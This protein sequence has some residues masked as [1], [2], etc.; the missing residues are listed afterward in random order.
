MRSST[1]TG[2]RTFLKTAVAVSVAGSLLAGCA[3]SGTS[4]SGDGSSTADSGGTPTTSNNAGGGAANDG[5]SAFGGWLD[6][7]ANYDSVTDKTGASTVAVKVGAE[8]N[9]GPYAF[10]PPATRIGARTTITW[11]WTG[12]GGSH[13]VVAQ[14]GSFE[15]E[16]S[17]EK[18][19]TFEHTFD[20]SGT[21]KYS[22]EPHEAMG[23]KGVV[24]VE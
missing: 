22:C 6:N 24:V 11:K 9:N 7:T 19:Y 3:S 10:A 14:D 4:N 21:Y 13:N 15:S 8:G 18:G 17:T 2:R 20:R 5:A 23:M 1:P 12:K 16:L